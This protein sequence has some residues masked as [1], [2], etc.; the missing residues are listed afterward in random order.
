MTKVS[1][2]TDEPRISVNAMLR[3]RALVDVHNERQRQIDR[4]GWTEYHDDTQHAAGGDIALAAA[5]YAIAGLPLAA[6]A[7]GLL[8]EALRKRGWEVRP[9]LDRRDNLVRAG[10]LIIA[11]IERLDRAGE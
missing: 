4:K 3:L 5:A 9:K 2:A 1:I 11:E 10:A 6:L 7:L 8:L